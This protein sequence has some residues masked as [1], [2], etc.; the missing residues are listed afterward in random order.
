MLARQRQ[1]P[2]KAGPGKASCW[3]FTHPRGREGTPTPAFRTCTF[4]PL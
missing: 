3:G 2:A 1:R 4:I